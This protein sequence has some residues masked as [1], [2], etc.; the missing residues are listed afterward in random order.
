MPPSTKDDRVGEAGPTTIGYPRLH[1][2]RT[3]STNE[4]ARMLA[5]EGAPHGTLVTAGEQTA[6]RGRQ[7]RAWVAP[8]GSALLCSLV[9]R[10]PPPLLSLIA[11]VAVCEVV[12]AHSIAGHTQR[13]HGGRARVKWPN[14]IVVEAPAAPQPSA[15]A[16]DEPRGG[17]SRGKAP[18]AARL[19]KLAG[20]LVEGRPQERWAI[21]GIGL[22]VAVRVEQLPDEMREGAASLGLPASAIEPLL[23]QLMQA[24]QRRL[25]EPVESVLDSWRAHDALLGREVSWGVH[26]LNPSS[27]RGDR[28]AGHTQRA[29][30][31]RAAGIDDTGRLIVRLAD[32]ATAK[33]DAG[34]IH[35]KPSQ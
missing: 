33:L 5:I 28:R 10:D 1:L 31:G 17:P 29:H 22:N 13:A 21:L 7:G 16:A 25:A 2:R 20:I 3:D 19:T 15:M 30:G 6:G 4:R 18:N 23:G 32:G 24:L 9:L 27:D 14:D 34:E 12:D 26:D 35:L 11:G 8:A